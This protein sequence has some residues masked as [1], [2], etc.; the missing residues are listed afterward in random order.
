MI[1]SGSTDASL[2]MGVNLLPP[3]CHLHGH[4]TFPD[5]SANADGVE[6]LAINASIR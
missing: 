4:L 2:P 6:V 5:K 1:V 3:P